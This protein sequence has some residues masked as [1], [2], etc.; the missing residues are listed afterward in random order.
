[1]NTKSHA[2]VSMHSLLLAGLAAAAIACGGPEDAQVAE[3]ESAVTSPAL[4]LLVPDLNGAFHI[5]RTVSFTALPSSVTWRAS[6]DGASY[7]VAASTVGSLTRLSVLRSGSDQKL[8]FRI[9]GRDFS[10][11]SVRGADGKI[12][13]TYGGGVL[14]ATD[15]PAPTADDVPGIAA[16]F[17]GV[18]GDDAGLSASLAL[19]A[20]PQV[21]ENAADDG[22]TSEAAVLGF[23]GGLL[24]AIKGVIKVLGALLG[25]GG[26]AGPECPG[27]SS[28]SCTDS[29]GH[30]S[31]VTCSDC[32]AHCV[33][34]YGVGGT[35]CDC[36][37]GI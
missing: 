29:A 27:G 1:M 30:Q 21:L 25:G 35:L 16:Y 34:I 19:F 22:T 36:G 32:S 9:N 4:E 18:L 15:S 37:C 13:M 26:G 14:P 20:F 10:V 6:V 2:S 8:I 7:T 11:E 3:A 5:V 33:Q 28:A 23:L 24:K 31:N 12:G 17:Q